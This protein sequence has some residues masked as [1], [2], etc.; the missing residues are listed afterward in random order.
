MQ[1]ASVLLHDALAGHL[2]GHLTCRAGSPKTPKDLPRSARPQQCFGTRSVN[3][4]G[5]MLGYAALQCPYVGHTWIYSRLTSGSMLDAMTATPRMVGPQ[6]CSLPS[7][8]I[9]LCSC[10]QSRAASVVFV[11]SPCGH[12]AEASEASQS[13]ADGRLEGCSRSVTADPWSRQ[14][15]SNS[16]GAKQLQS[17]GTA[18]SSHHNEN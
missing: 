3:P 9:I 14:R 10:S 17:T 5:S 1:A 18:H 6:R 15:R 12:H 16:F 11:T 7:Q 8:T 13:H 2:D 4:H